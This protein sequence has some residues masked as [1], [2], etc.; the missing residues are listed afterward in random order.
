MTVPILENKTFFYHN[1]N[2]LHRRHIVMGGC[3]V[4]KLIFNKC[5][6]ATANTYRHFL[7]LLII[8]ETNMTEQ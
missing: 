3:V 7:S 8:I 1:L 6:Q 5:L 2:Q 4:L